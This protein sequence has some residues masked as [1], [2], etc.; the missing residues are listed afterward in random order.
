MF[1][2]LISWQFVQK[3]PL[4]DIFGKPILTVADNS[5]PWWVLFEEAI[6]N[7]GG[8]V[9]NP[10]ILLGSTDASFFRQRG[11]PAI[12][13]SAIAHTP[14]RVHDH[15]EVHRSLLSFTANYQNCVI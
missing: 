6:Q 13:F 12:G 8:T 7:A 1:F 10:E 14:D 4:L 2:S 9:E 5:N 15:D 11:V 3:D